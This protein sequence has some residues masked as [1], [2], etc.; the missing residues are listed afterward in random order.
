M[1]LAAGAVTNT[2]VALSWTV[3]S[4]A[5]SYTI[6][7]NG[8]AVGTSTT[9]AYTDTGLTANTQYSY[10]INAT[11]VK[12]TS[13]LSSTVVATTSNASVPAQ[14]TGLSAGTVTAT[15]IGLSWTAVSGATSYSIYRNGVSTPIGTS[16]TTSYTDTGVT[17]GNSYVYN[18]AASNANGVGAQSTSLTVSTPAVGYSQTSTNTVV[19]QYVAGHLTLAQYLALGAEYGYTATITLYDCSGTWTNQSNCGPMK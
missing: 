3:D 11:N 1:G 13:G 7:R 5:T 6:Y 19:N 12:G 8:S 16:T 17:A 10:A 14:V 2:T 15:S 9:N 18:V 4:G